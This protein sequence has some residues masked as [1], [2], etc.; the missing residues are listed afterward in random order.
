LNGRDGV[1]FFWI[2]RLYV[3]ILG[4]AYERKFGVEFVAFR[5]VMVVGAG[6]TSATSPWRN[7]IFECLGSAESREVF[8]PYRPDET[9]PLVHADEIANMLATLASA[10]R[11]SHSI[12]NSFGDC[13]TSGELKKEIESL[14]PN[15]RVIL[16]NAT[17]T[18]CARAIDSSRF[19]REFGVSPLGFWQRLRTEAQSLRTTA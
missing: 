16:G 12:Y 2:L 6:G 1:L 17:L 13:V 7:Q 4:E 14:N 8:I 18:G 19:A 11:C 15:V 10:Q 9:L 3:E 5:M